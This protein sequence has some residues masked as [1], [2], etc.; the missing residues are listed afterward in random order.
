MLKI[1][2]NESRNLFKLNRTVK[3][4]FLIFSFPIIKFLLIK[5]N[6]V[7]YRQI[8]VFQRTNSDF[9]PLLFPFIVVLVYA[10]YLIPEIKNGYLFFVTS[11]TQLKTYIQSKLI[12]N[13]LI[14]FLSAFLLIFLPFIFVMYIEPSL[15]IISLDQAGTN[16]IAYLLFE[17]LLD[18]TI[19][20][21]LFEQLLDHGLLTYGVVYSFWVGV[22]GALYSTFALLLLFLGKT[23]LVSFSIPFI[24]YIVGHFITQLLGIDYLSPMLTI[25]PFSL[26][27]QPIWIIFIPFIVL[28]TI[29]AILYFILRNR[30]AG[31]YE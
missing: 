5:D 15:N 20:M 28:I 13:A 25:F 21:Q 18:Q 26:E 4:L 16:P 27:L 2:Q 10:F 12:M 22:N 17:Q 11:R 29:T 24:Y 8:E 6:Y 31:S 14:S 1:L 23:P 19:N 9:V 30:L 3:W 7:F